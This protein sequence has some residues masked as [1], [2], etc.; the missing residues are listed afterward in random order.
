[1]WRK[2]MPANKLKEMWAYKRRKC[3]LKG[4]VVLR[5]VRSPLHRR[6]GWGTCRHLEGECIERHTEL[7]EIHSTWWYLWMSYW[8]GSVPSALLIPC[9]SGWMW[10]KRYLVLKRW[11]ERDTLDPESIHTSDE[12]QWHLKVVRTIEMVFMLPLAA[13]MVMVCMDDI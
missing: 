1:M 9:I 11:Y 12:F 6:S 4:D 10:G 13:T 3:I 2:Y 5:I 7:V 8:Q